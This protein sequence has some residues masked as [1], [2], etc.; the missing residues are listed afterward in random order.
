MDECAHE[1]AISAGFYTHPFISD[2]GVAGFNR[3]NGNEFGTPALQFTKT[4]LYWVG[5]VIFRD[6]EQQEV[7]CVLPIGF[8]K[9]PEGAT[10]RIETGCGHVHGTKAAMGRIIWRAKL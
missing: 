8:A 5:R 6:T 7:F 2:G 4:H 3:V 10:E 9:L 1:K